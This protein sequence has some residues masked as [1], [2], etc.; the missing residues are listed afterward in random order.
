MREGF[1][2]LL[3]FLALAEDRSFTRAARRLGVSQ[4][5]LSHRIKRLETRMGVRLF[6]RTTRSV[7]PT[8]AGERLQATLAPRVAEIEAEMAAL[9]E[10]RDKPAGRVRIS[11]SDHAL[12]SV[13]WPRLGPV[14]AD[15]P[16]IRVELHVDNAFRNIVEEGFDAGV[17]LGE[18]VE[19]DMI[20]LRIGP[21]WRLAVVASPDYLRRHGAPRHPKDLIA[22]N[23]VNYRHTARGGLQPWEFEANGETLRVRVEGQLTFNGPLAMTDAVLAGHGLGWLPLDLVAD[24]L[25]SGRL[26]EVLAPWSPPFAG[27]FLYYPSRHQNLPAFRVVAEALRH[28]G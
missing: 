5:T 26:V 21:D 8:E 25:A 12:H 11:L 22:H 20:A 28:R 16:D 9:T 14:I 18:S 10:Y 27:Y 3:W 23:C 19:A 17:R 15:Y 13:V 7:A 4:S 1:N 6:H 2:D 24:H